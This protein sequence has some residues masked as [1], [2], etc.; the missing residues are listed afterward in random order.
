MVRGGGGTLDGIED[1]WKPPRPSAGQKAAGK[2][3]RALWMDVGGK[4]RDWQI[5][6]PATASRAIAGSRGQCA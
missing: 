4:G 1:G 5:N 2:G 6:G 3:R